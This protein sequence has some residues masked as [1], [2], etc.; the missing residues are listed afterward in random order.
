MIRTSDAVLITLLNIE[1][2]RKR[3]SQ[4]KQGQ[5]A[6]LELHKPVCRPWGAFESIRAGKNFQVKS[7]IVKPGAK[8]SL[9]S[10]RCRSEHW[11]VVRGVARIT[12]DDAV[13]DLEP[14]H[15]TYIPLGARHR[16]ENPGGDDLEVIEVQCGEYLGEDDITR[17]EDDFGRT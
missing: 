5:R 6:E 13:F 15:S 11:T 3:G 9:Q 16:L 12:C 4:M 8:L 1:V 14:N 10:H 2:T 7:L 17:Y